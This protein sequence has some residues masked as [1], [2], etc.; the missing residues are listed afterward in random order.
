MRSA[1]ERRAASS[2]L[3][4]TVDHQPAA[5]MFL[6]VRAGARGAGIDTNALAARLFDQGYLLA[7]GSLFSPRQQPSPMLRFN[8]ATSSN[9]AMLGGA[10]GGAGRAGLTAP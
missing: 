9:P 1:T 8:I 4:L 3:G 7:P 6:W 10:G 5:G 2:G